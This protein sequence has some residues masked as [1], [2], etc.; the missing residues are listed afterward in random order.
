ME[1]LCRICGSGEVDELISVSCTVSSHKRTVGE[2]ISAVMGLRFSLTQYDRMHRVPGQL[3]DQCLARLNRA[4]AV[5]KRCRYASGLARCKR[6]EEDQYFRCRICASAEAGELISV[7]YVCNAWNVQ[8]VTMV[9]ELTAVRYRKGDG[10]PAFVCAECLASLNVAYEFR[11]D[12]LASAKAFEGAS[13]EGR[14]WQMMQ[15][16]QDEPQRL[17]V[18]LASE[19]RLDAK[20]GVYCS[21]CS[22]V[23][24]GEGLE[25]TCV[26]CLLEFSNYDEIVGEISKYGKHETK[27]ENDDGEDG[28]DDGPAYESVDEAETEDKSKVI[29]DDLKEFVQYK[30]EE[31]SAESS[32]LA[33]LP[34]T[35]KPT[36]K[37]NFHIEDTVEA[38]CCVTGC[39]WT[40]TQ[41]EQLWHLRHLHSDL[42]KVKSESKLFCRFCDKLFPSLTQL[43]N[44]SIRK[45][46]IFKCLFGGCTF[47]AKNMGRIV[48]HYAQH[49]PDTPTIGPP[50][51]PASQAENHIA[52]EQIT[53]YRC[54]VKNCHQSGSMDQIQSHMNRVHPNGMECRSGAYFCQHCERS[55][56]DNDTLRGHFQRQTTLYKCTIDGCCMSSKVKKILLKHCTGLHQKVF[57]IRPVN[58]TRPKVTARPD[59]GNFNVVGSVDDCID[60]LSRKGEWCCTCLK[61]FATEEY[62]RQHRETNHPIEGEE[63]Q[64]SSFQCTQC[65][66]CFADA[67]EL[68]EHVK[69]SAQEQHYY[70]RAC[71]YLMWNGRELVRHRYLVHGQP[72]EG[73]DDEAG[74]LYD[75][76]PTGPFRCCGCPSIFY[77]E[78]DLIDHRQ[79]QHETVESVATSVQFQCDHCHRVFDTM[80]TYREHT[81]KFRNLLF[82][83]KIA[84]CNFRTE[85][86]LTIKEHV[87]PFVVHSHVPPPA[88]VKLFQCCVKG[89]F[90]DDA[91]YWAVTLHGV[92]S[93]PEIRAANADRYQGATFSCQACCMGFESK[94][95]RDSHVR[96]RCDQQRM[97]CDQCPRIFSGKIALA[98]HLIRYHGMA[99]RKANERSVCNICGKQVSVYNMK[100]HLDVHNDVRRWRCTECPAAFNYK[101]LLQ[102]HA[103][104]HSQE[105]PAVCR[106]GCGKRYRQTVDRN[107]HEKLAHQSDQPLPYAC[108]ECDATFVR[109]RDLRLH[110]RKHTGLKLFPCG[111][112]GASFDLLR[113]IESHREV[114]L[115]QL[116]QD[117]GYVEEYVVAD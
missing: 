86:R 18:E 94:L 8:I 24:P 90:F 100:A 6:G 59:L 80:Q 25:K 34:K 60:V 64:P 46:T 114:C 22:A 53:E 30:R 44:H 91:S 72:T 68:T 27:V 101:T 81:D 3:C 83:C 47:S 105:R 19:A 36:P 113:E 56:P 21:I 54:C 93:H 106:Y 112:C 57:R 16:R 104:T 35:V 1:D 55:F 41:D 50:V 23:N 78:A 98:A 110:S 117:M 108:S 4:Y 26:G 5:W 37:T 28:M 63:D 51:I 29:E 70:C 62:L 52:A 85:K 76:E 66:A 77:Y 109:D 84:D 102:K 89:C 42:D 15:F 115:G 45:K 74:R 67:N 48:L 31:T 103:L 71:A 75:E 49:G 116:E 38:I 58:S 111:R 12:A 88:K 92:E 39:V 10:L 97:A 69:K 82:R 11:R 32:A 13:V 65:N 96:R 14:P 99:A 87:S 73:D 17:V 95:L 79:V 20:G 40:G 2:M 43:K 7:A 9:H 33:Y 107:R 61:L